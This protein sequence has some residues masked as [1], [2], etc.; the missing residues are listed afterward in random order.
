MEEYNAEEHIEDYEVTVFVSRHGYLKKITP[1][2]LRMASEQ[3]FKEDDGLSR[4]FET[5]NASELLVFTDKCQTYKVKVSDFEDSK[6]SVL[7][8]YLPTKLEMD[9][10]ESV[11]FVMD[12]GNYEGNLLFFY[13]N[14]KVARVP[15]SAYWTKTNRKKLANAYSD[16]IVLKSIVEFTEDTEV[17][18]YTSDGRLLI[19]N[20]ALLAPKATRNTQGVKAVNLKARHHIERAQ[21]LSETPV[22]NFDRYKV[23]RIPAAGA[24]LKPEDKGEEQLSLL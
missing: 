19:F 13:E 8:V 7:G 16:K 9:E 2:Y 24:L 15:V 20:T 23:K 22:K 4:S 3:K 10:D 6:A 1:Q 18:V 12:A 14:G 21:L 5:T 17:A 11:I